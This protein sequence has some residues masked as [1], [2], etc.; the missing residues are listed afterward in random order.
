MDDC[1]S[2]QGGFTQHPGASICP[3]FRVVTVIWWK[4][5]LFAGMG[6]DSA[7][8]YILPNPWF[9]I[10]IALDSYWSHRALLF[11]SAFNI[12]GHHVVSVNVCCLPVSNLSQA[13]TQVWHRSTVTLNWCWSVPD[14]C[15]KLPWIVFQ[16]VFENIMWLWTLTITHCYQEGQFLTHFVS[17][18][19]EA[20]P[21]HKY[22][23]LF[24]LSQ[25][26]RR[27][28]KDH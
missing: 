18:L 28:L 24:N 1:F 2:I 15:S 4:N 19:E 23:L 5:A 20:W 25:Y 8:S 21:M 14:C 9:L 16:T 7:E 17:L 10:T 12:S 13:I 6:K 27:A 26:S 3:F 22:P 11:P